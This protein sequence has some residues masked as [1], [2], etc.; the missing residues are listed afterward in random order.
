VVAIVLDYLQVGCQVIILTGFLGKEIRRMQSKRHADAHHAPARFGRRA[1]RTGGS[2]GIEPGQGQGY[3]CDP[4]EAT[5]VMLH[6]KS[7]RGFYPAAPLACFE[8]ACFGQSRER[9]SESHS[10][11]HESCER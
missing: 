8:T 1:Q 3:T 6:G 2:K 7:S 9:A 10:P 11:C 5:T 4:K